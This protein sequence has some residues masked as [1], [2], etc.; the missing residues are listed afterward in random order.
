M[1]RKPALL[2]AVLSLAA[3]AARPAPTKLGAV[4]QPSSCPSCVQD[5]PAATGNPTGS[6]L[7]AWEALSPVD[8]RGVGARFFRPIGSAKGPDFKAVAAQPGTTVAEPRLAGNDKGFVLVWTAE[9]AGDTDV[10]ARRYSPTAVPVGAPFQVNVDDPALPRAPEDSLAEVSLRADGSFAVAWLR[11]VP[12]YDGASPGVPPAIFVRRFSPTGAPLAA[13]VQVSTGLVG[14]ARPALCVSTTGATTV[15]WTSIDQRAPFEPS[16]E[17]ASLRRL[18]PTG[19]P[20]GPTLVLSAAKSQRARVAAA[21]GRD[22]GAVVAWSTELPP[23]AADGDVLAQRFAKDGKKA[24]AVFVVNSNRAGPQ[25]APALSFDATGFFVAA[26]SS[27]DGLQDAI[28]VRR[29]SAAGVATSPDIDVF[30]DAGDGGALG[31]P[32]LAHTKS[33]AFTVLWRNNFRHLFA[34][35]FKP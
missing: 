34:Q 35:K 32:A 6:L 10:W 12:F 14:E 5:Q 31:A 3:A 25:G 16:L 28:R 24:G 29:F 20:Q 4:F 23:A 26:W 27:R 22:G 18:Q 1:T 33:G 9:S 17:G 11:F 19:A 2:L 7:V 8:T 13:P 21:C 30:D 15:A